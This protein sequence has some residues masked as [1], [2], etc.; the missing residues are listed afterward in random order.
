M[1]Y[2]LIDSFLF[3]L[4]HTKFSYPNVQAKVDELKK[5]LQTTIGLGWE[6]RLQNVPDF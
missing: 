5:W 2:S 1:L 3:T 4:L 6:Q